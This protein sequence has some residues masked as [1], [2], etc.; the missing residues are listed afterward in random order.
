MDKL[1]IRL[2][3]IEDNVI[4][5]NMVRQYLLQVPQARFEVTPART[6]VDGLKWLAWNQADVV[7]LDL[8]L[9]DGYG[10]DTLE[11]LQDQAHDTPIVILTNID[12]EEVAIKAIGDGAQD[13]LLKTRVDPQRLYRAIRF[14][15]ERQRLVAEL[16]GH[17][18][19][20]LASLKERRP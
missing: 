5:A 3:L 20:K 2:L 14:A 17:Y 13:Y 11:R 4:E 10:L 6:L 8:Q 1:V 16:K 7:L 19:D 18:E 15:M 9:P 12:E